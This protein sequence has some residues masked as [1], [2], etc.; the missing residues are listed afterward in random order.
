MNNKTSS[1]EIKRLLGMKE[2][3]PR[4]IIHPTPTTEYYYRIEGRP[5]ELFTYN[6]LQQ[7]GVKDEQITHKIHRREVR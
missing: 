6:Q 5:F 2:Y 4:Q 1:A 3:Y 7:M